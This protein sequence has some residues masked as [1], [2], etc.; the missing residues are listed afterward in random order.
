[1][2]KIPLSQGKFALVDD[3]DFEVLSAFKWSVYNDNHTFYAK[4]TVPR[5]ASGKYKVILMHREILGDE[6][7]GLDT[8]HIDCDGLNNQR[9][10]LRPCTRSQNLCNQRRL[11]K[12][13]SGYK[14]VDWNKQTGKWRARIRFNGKR[15]HIGYFTDLAEAHAARNAAAERMHGEFAREA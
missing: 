14:G 3:A 9:S 12:N 6:C 8:D 11:S 10:N 15:H 5:D 1:M 2:K 13:T 7:D 4:R